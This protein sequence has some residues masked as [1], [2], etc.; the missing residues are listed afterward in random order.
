MNGIHGHWSSS[1]FCTEPAMLLERPRDWIYFL[2][3]FIVYRKPSGLGINYTSNML[4]FLLFH[5]AFHFSL[6]SAFLMLE[7]TWRLRLDNI[8]MERICFIL[9]IH[10][11]MRLRLLFRLC[12]SFWIARS[13]WLAV[14]RRR[15]ERFICCASKVME[16]LP[17]RNNRAIFLRV[18][19]REKF[20]LAGRNPF[21][22]SVHSAQL[23]NLKELSVH[24]CVK[25][26]L[27]KA[28]R[29]AIVSLNKFLLSL[30]AFYNINFDS[31]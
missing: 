9:K 29:W 2:A 28:A 24:C 11:Q 1:I 10:R 19:F 5:L 25:C 16:F 13:V 17:N 14:W 31:L 20:M 15:E 8:L 3:P 4:L 30:F 26:L 6:R 18:N 23:I 22:E 27:D 12:V 21:A 7:W